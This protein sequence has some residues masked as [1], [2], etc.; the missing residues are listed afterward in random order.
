M[1][2]VDALIFWVFI[3]NTMTDLENLEKEIF[4]ET[5]F[6]M[7]Y[8]SGVYFV[9]ARTIYNDFSMGKEKIL[10]IG[11]SK[12]IGKRLSSKKHPYRLLFDKLTNHSVYTRAVECQDYLDVE[13]YFIRKFKPVLNKIFK[14][15]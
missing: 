9:C 10:Y 7:P 8:F 13:I 6:C 5:N 3:F 12:S 1:I 11:S 4:N 2:G 15:G 14:N